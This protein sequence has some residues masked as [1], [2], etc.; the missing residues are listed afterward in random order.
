MVMTP[1]GNFYWDIDIEKKG[2][3][4]I[5]CYIDKKGPILA[6][7]ITSGRFKGQLQCP[8]CNRILEDD[9]SEESQQSNP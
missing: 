9:F 8:E 2:P 6:K 7:K 3:Y 4:C 1:S 5:P